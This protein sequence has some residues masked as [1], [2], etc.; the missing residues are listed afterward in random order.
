MDSVLGKKQLNNFERV[1]GSDMSKNYFLK[2]CVKKSK[3][4]EMFFA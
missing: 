4:F 2:F 3:I 1:R